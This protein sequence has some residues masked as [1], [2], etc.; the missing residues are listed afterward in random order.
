MADKKQKK[1]FTQQDIMQALD[2]CYG[3]AVN[4]LGNISPSVDKFAANYLEKNQNA[5]AA[6]QSMIKYQIA[7]CTTS[8][9]VTG[10]GG[11]ITLPVA[12]P[13][14]LSSVLYVQLRM[15]ACTAYMA[16]YDVKSDQV[17]TLVY[18]CLAG[19]S[20]GEVL[21][22]VGVKVGEKIAEGAV[23]KI[24]G[25]VL[26]KINQK[27]GFRLLTKFGTKGVINIGKAVPVIGG[28]ITGGMDLVET[29]FIADRA[30]KMFF[31]GVCVDDTSSEHTIINAEATIL[32]DDEKN[33]QRGSLFSP[34][35]IELMQSIGLDYD[36]NNLTEDDDCWAEIEEKVGDFLTMECLGENYA[37]NGNGIIC[38]SILNKIPV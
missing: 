27:V 24:P 23:K 31:E 13:A 19:I 38:K 14:N 28:V 9:F 1:E 34:E 26:T 12:V 30:Y 10:L 33:I 15:I 36:F 7:K 32:E 37:P 29:K 16:G 5:E 18:A 3:K 35:E 6:A 2:W 20:V 4:G 22:Q 8:G 25:A 21:K 17:Q 11:L